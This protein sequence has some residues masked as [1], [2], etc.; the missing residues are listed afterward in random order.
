MLGPYLFPLLFA[1]ASAQSLP[2][3]Q[4]EVASIVSPIWA[5]EPSRDSAGEAAKVIR[6]LGI[7]PGQTVADIGAGS[8]YY[9]MRV[10]P[11]VGPTGTVIAQDIVPRYLDQLKSRVRKAGLTNVKFVRGTPADPRLPAASVD[12]ALLIHMYH[13]I[14]RPYDLLYRLRASLKPGGQIAIVDLERPAEYH[15]MPKAL[16]ACEVK[17]VGYSLVSMTDL[18]P[19]YLAIFKPSTAVDPR[20]V[21]ACRG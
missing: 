20:S 17:A 7:G 2:A 9:T 14:E 16:L 1:A 4:R 12:V 3:P 21:K 8:G 19:G 6:A 5:D 18:N 11:V 15:G 13:E 10:A